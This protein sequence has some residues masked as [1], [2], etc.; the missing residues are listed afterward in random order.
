[1]PDSAIRGSTLA[2]T[3]NGRF[4]VVRQP[5]GVHVIDALGPRPRQRIDAPPGTVVACVGDEVWW[6]GAGGELQRA[7]LGHDEAP[8]TVVRLDEAIT[9]ITAS[10]DGTSA[11]AESAR[12]TWLVE[13]HG[14][15]AV[16]ID[17][18]AGT[19]VLAVAGRRVV[20]AIRDQATIRT[21]GR[22]DV[23]R[24]PRPGGIAVA[25]TFVL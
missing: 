19:R 7:A 16:E 15:T 24:L 12:R 11:L 18:E 22:T 17:C 5:D 10:A 25:A 21:A 9:S 3:R 8:R 14:A 4:V 6:V 1:M 23:V 2:M 13:A 20:E